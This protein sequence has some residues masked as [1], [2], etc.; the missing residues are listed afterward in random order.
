[1][2]FTALYNALV[3]KYVRPAVRTVDIILISTEDL[4][5]LINW[6]LKDFTNSKK[7]ILVKDQELCCHM[8]N[9]GGQTGEF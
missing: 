7:R 1:M 3:N 5:K 4:R 8:A 2:T 6:S 9:L